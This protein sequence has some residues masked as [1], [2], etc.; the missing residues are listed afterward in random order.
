MGYHLLTTSLLLFF[1]YT[2]AQTPDTQFI[3][4]QATITAIESNISGR[5]SKEIATVTF[6]TES[7]DSI[8]SQTRLLHIPLL[9]SFKKVGDTITVLYQKENP[10]L[11][12]TENESF[13]QAYGIYIF[14][15]LGILVMGYRFIRRKKVA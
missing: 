15:A 13:L 6:T 2:L 3:E 4:T 10:Y 12:K 1:G 5:S 9:G 11:I 14:I 8:T 7:G